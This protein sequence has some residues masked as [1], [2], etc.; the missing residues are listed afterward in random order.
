MTVASF[1]VEEGLEK[2][3]LLRPPA[4]DLDVDGGLV[5]QRL[6]P[7]GSLGLPLL[8]LQRLDVIQG[9]RA[10]AGAEVLADD[11]ALVFPTL[12]Q[13]ALGAPLLPIGH[14]CYLLPG[15]PARAG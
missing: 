7:G 15:A 13:V 14:V 12:G 4:L 3:I 8:P 9:F 11:A 2:E 5:G 6:A 10:R 1:G